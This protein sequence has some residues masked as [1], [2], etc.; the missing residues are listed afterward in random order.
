[1]ASEEAVRLSAIVHG[2]V[3]G[4]NFRYHTQRKARSLG[5]RGYVRN[6]ADGSVEV[7][8][9]GPRRAVEDL[10][11]WLHVGAPM[12]EVWRVDATWEAPVGKWASFEVR[13]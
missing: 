3:Q 7:V 10:Y 6:R 4:V 12:A 11:S 1:M 5:L 9:E 13:F 2:R 8:A